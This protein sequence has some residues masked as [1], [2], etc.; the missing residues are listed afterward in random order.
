MTY[1]KLNIEIR[2]FTN[3]GIEIALDLLKSDT[4]D[5]APFVITKNGLDKKLK[6]FFGT[7]KNEAIESA[8]EFIEEIEETP[9]LAM[10]IYKDKIKFKDGDLDSIILHIYGAEEESGYSYGQAYKIE[11][12]NIILLNEKYSLVK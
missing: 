11:N 2:E 8:E 6:K 7:S 5:I 12:G 4:S 3:E 1:E 9:D 10:L